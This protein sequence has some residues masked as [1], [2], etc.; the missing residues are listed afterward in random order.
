MC[1]LEIPFDQDGP[2]ELVYACHRPPLL[3]SLFSWVP[4][5]A[6]RAT[7]LEPDVLVVPRIHK[8]VRGKY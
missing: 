4:L 1:R 6:N 8:P 3:C 2:E 5:P 7:V